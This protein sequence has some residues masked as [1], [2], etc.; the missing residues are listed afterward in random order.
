[1]FVRFALIFTLIVWVVILSN[2]VAAQKT[3]P[4]QRSNLKRCS[5][6]V[7]NSK[8]IFEAKPIYLKVVKEAQVEGQIIVMLRVDE[9]GKVHE[10]TAFSGHNKSKYLY[11]SKY[12]S[13]LK[14][15]LSPTAAIRLLFVIRYF[16]QG[17]IIR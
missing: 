9:S 10:A 14:K 12:L 11:K 7:I 16:F 4:K 3:R 1:M 6:G 2:S 5:G 8:V 15:N 17:K 13:V